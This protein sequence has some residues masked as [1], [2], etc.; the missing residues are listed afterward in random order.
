[1]VGAGGRLAPRLAIEQA[2]RLKAEG[3]PVADGRVLTT[4]LRTKL[5]RVPSGPE[6]A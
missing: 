6:F 4:N 2:R 1:V 5:F 3:V